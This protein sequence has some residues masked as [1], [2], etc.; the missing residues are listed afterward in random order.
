MEIKDLNPSL[1]WGL[2]DQI[3]Q[4]PRPSRKEG[5]IVEFLLDFAQKHQLEVHKD[6]ALNVIIRKPATP[7]KEKLQTVILQSHTDMVC[8]KNNDV[9]FN[10]ET[11]PIQTYVDG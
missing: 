11:D 3:T 1:I 7:G 9:T 6:E 4:V 2:F 8:E 10:F 5:K